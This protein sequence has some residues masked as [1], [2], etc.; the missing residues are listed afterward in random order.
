MNNVVENLRY[1]TQLENTRNT[2]RFRQDIDSSLVGKERYKEV[3][4]QNYQENMKD[5]DFREKERERKKACAKK[6]YHRNKDN[7]EWKENKREINKKARSK[8]E[9][10]EKNKAYRANWNIK[11][12]CEC[13]SSVYKENLSTHIKTK[14][15]QHYETISK[16]AQ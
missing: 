12:E 16:E 5:P 9:F 14:K 1:T 13:G 10:Q 11:I 7:E 6:L 3:M 15:H 2:A 4:K 8:P